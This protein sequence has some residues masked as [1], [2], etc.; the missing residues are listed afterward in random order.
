[1]TF[2]SLFRFRRP[3]RDLSRC[4]DALEDIARSLRIHWKTGPRRKG[5]VTEISSV[6]FEAINKDWREKQAEL[7]IEAEE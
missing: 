5:S 3:L 1:M 7:G 6:D 4:A 2:R